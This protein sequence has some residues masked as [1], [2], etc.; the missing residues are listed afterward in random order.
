M[1]VN[2]APYK[3]RY[4]FSANTVADALWAVGSNEEFE[5]DSQLTFVKNRG[6]LPEHKF[7]DLGCGCLR[8]SAKIVQYLDDG[9]FHGADISEGLMQM[10]PKRLAMLNITRTPITHLINDY[11]FLKLFNEKFHFILSVSILTHLLPDAILPFFTGVAKILRGDGVF[12]FTMYPTEKP[13]HEG[14]I[15]VSFYNKNWLIEQGKKAGLKIED[16]PGDYPNPSPISNY[17]ERVNFPEVAQWVMKG[18]LS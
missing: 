11:E 17:I 3:D 7:L 6:L 18:T 10:I 4:A 12:Y 15:E 16:I 9:N 1:T 5:V 14:D 2:L 13:I 8:G